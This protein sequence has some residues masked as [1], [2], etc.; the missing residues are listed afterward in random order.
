MFILPHNIK[1][2]YTHCQKSHLLFLKRICGLLYALLKWPILFNY[3]AVWHAPRKRRGQSRAL[4][5]DYMT[6]EREGIAAR[7]IASR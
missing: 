7:A 3:R 1:I 4:S 5:C 6:Y 2:Q